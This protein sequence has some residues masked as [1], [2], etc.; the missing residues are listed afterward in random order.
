MPPSIQLRSEHV[1]PY[2]DRLDRHSPAGHRASPRGAARAG[3]TGV[4]EGVLRILGAIPG[5]ELVDLAQ[6]RVGC[7]CN[8]RPVADYK[9]R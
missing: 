3:R 4:T 1:V 5:L 2:I 7:M 6:P 8:R 9:R